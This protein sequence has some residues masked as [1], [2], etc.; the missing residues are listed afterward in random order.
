MDLNL[1][2]KKV[3]VT[4]GSRG[5]GFDCCRLFLEEG[6][7]VTLV[8]SDEARVKSAVS[9]LQQ[10]GAMINGLSVDLSSRTL[11]QKLLEKLGEVDVVVNNA[12]A[13]PGGGL[14]KVSD[15]VWRSAWELK[16][17]GYLNVTRA[18]LPSMLARGSGV[19]INV[20]GIAGAA[21]RYDYISGSTAN[22]A[23]IAFT[24]ATGAHA[25]RNGVRVV[26]VNPG[27]TETDRLVNLYRSRAAERFGDP[28][29]WKEMLSDMPF[30]RAAKA[31]EI[32]SLVVFLS[33]SRS[34]YVN[35]TVID[36]D[37]GACYMG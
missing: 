22:A 34:A 21:P 9:R 28:E 31:E 14:D 11:P 12:G 5:I 37:G 26:G 20:I 1:Q 24:K 10:P 27:P 23:L 18:A 33:S 35:G 25:S 13:I 19:I 3:L 30:G 15:E 29:R 8:A 16:L 2:G 7:D 6:C 32:A 4:G 17:F 36:V